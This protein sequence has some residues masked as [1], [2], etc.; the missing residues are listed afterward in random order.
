MT[1]LVSLESDQPDYFHRVMSGC[2]RLS[3]AGWEL[4]GLADLLSDPDQEMFDV[5]VD[6]EGRREQQGFVPPAQARAFLRSA[7]ET[8]LNG[9]TPPKSPLA[10]AYFRGI[11][12]TPVK[13]PNAPGEPSTP[14]ALPA[15]PSVEEASAD[16]LAAIIALVGG[17]DPAA[18]RPR[19]L[20]QDGRSDGIGAS[21]FEARMQFVGEVDATAFAARSEGLAYLV[22]TIVAGCSIQGRT[23]APRQASDAAAAICSLGME[24]WPSSWLGGSAYDSPSSELP[25]DFLLDHDLITAFQVGWTILYTQVAMGT[26][27]RLIHVLS[28]LRSEDREIQSGL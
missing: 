9:P 16:T 7:R 23:F 21:P 19:A 10:R 27:E 13:R 6:R 8:R 17:S 5:A 26:A 15:S 22:N 28:D 12:R 11:D 2:R 18:M 25:K 3:N 24:N 20:L 14:P 1:V 4:D